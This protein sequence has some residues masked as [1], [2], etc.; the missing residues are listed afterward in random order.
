MRRCR[1][2]C[3]ARCPLDVSEAVPRT[4]RR[5]L[6]QRYLLAALMSCVAGLT[7]AQSITIQTYPILN[8]GVNAGP[9]PVQYDGARY[10]GGYGSHYRP[11]PHRSGWRGHDRWQGGPPSPGFHRPGFR[12]PGHRAPGYG[13]PSN[14]RQPGAGRPGYGRPGYGHQGYHRGPGYGSQN[15]SAPRW[16]RPGPSQRWNGGPRGW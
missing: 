5:S 16:Q 12:D 7:H 13:G 4:T 9:P 10:H 2:S 14:Y 8:Y 1:I 11:Q 6:M 15:H 3:S